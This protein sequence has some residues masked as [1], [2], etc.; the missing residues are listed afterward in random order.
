M[1]GRIG[2]AKTRNNG[3]WTEAAFRSFIKGNLRRVT[4]RWAPISECLKKARTK[5]G[6]YMCAHCNEEVPT[7]TRDDNGKRVKNIICDHVIP[8]IDPAVGWV[9]WDETIDRMFSEPHN[10]QALC[11]A[12]H[13]IKS[14]EEKAVAK[15]RRDKLKEIG[16]IED[17]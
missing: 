5:R 8:I 2:G 16:I 9:S 6:Y 13:K 10:L 17:E 12:C 4:M 11:Y 3:R 7:S 15:V 14:D 1:A